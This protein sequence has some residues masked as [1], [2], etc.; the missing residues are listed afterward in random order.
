MARPVVDDFE[1]LRDPLSLL[2]LRGFWG[3]PG[4][5]RSSSGLD[6][7]KKRV[8]TA[9]PV[10]HDER[11]NAFQQQKLG[12]TGPVH[13]LPWPQGHGSPGTLEQQGL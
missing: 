10:G 3:T 11:G 12:P 5:L 6:K 2:D 4:S 1:L 9:A 8:L 7:R 13:P